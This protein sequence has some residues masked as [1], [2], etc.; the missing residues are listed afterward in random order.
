MHDPAETRGDQ[1]HDLQESPSVTIVAEDRSPLVAA[2]RDVVDGPL[3]FEP[4]STR[5]AQMITYNVEL[6]LTPFLS[7]R[8]R[9][10]SPP[11]SQHANFSHSWASCLAA[12]L[13]SLAAWRLEVARNEAVGPAVW[14]RRAATSS[15]YSLMPG[16]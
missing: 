14:R 12:G 6:T 4:Q 9:L 2:A 10:R 11:G 7:H 16:D 13:P 3:V 5:Y 15:D 1:S 8:C